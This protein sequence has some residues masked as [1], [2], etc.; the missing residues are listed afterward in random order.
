MRESYLEREKNLLMTFLLLFN[1]LKFGKS[2]LFYC[3]GYRHAIFK[4]LFDESQVVY[5][6]KAFTKEEKKIKIVNEFFISVLLHFYDLNSTKS[7]YI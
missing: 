6:R 5:L 3:N 7:R 1:D 2:S 4:I